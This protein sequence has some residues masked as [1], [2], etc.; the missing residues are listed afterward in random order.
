MR[1]FIAFNLLFNT[2]LY[3]N[4]IGQL[5]KKDWVLFRQTSL[6]KNEEEYTRISSLLYCSSGKENGNFSLFIGSSS[7]R[8]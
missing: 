2:V 3:N 8:T 5:L 7:Q 6:G 1:R 4:S